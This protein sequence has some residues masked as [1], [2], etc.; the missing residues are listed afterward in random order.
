M[1]L[2]RRAP[3]TPPSS[4]A[5]PRRPATPRPGSAGLGPRGRRGAAPDFY[6]TQDTATKSSHQDRYH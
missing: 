1:A 4:P 5:S 3:G 2:G 6:E